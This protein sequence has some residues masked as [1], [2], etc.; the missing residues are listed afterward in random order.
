MTSPTDLE[1]L[2]DHIALLSAQI[3]S[4]TYDLLTLIREFDQ[5]EGWGCGFTSCA[6][7]LCWRIGLSPGAARKNCGYAREKVRVANALGELPLMS[8]A[9]QQGQ[10]SYS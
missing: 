10:V 9:M 8:A 7:W 3:H 5:R 4:A 2:S 6:H 1:T